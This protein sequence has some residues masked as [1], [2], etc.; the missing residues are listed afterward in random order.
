MVAVLS[1]CTPHAIR[2]AIGDQCTGQDFYCPSQLPKV[3]QAALGTH[4][5]A[6]QGGWHFGVA[7][8]MW[9]WKRHSRYH[10]VSWNWLNLTTIYC[11]SFPLEVAW[12]QSSKIV[13]YTG[14]IRSVQLLSKWEHRFLCS[15]FCRLPRILTLTLVFNDTSLSG[16][17]FNYGPTQSHS[18]FLFAI[19]Q[20]NLLEKIIFLDIFLT[21]IN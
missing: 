13:S 2:A 6:C 14:D 21:T 16:K 9:R 10:A 18:S 7:E 5:A 8:R 17:N 20:L 19:R 12:L 3:A 4:K 15:L 11:P 1:L